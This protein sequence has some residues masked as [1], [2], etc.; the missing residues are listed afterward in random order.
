VPHRRRRGSKL[1][2]QNPAFN[3]HVNPFL[4]IWRAPRPSGITDMPATV[5]RFWCRKGYEA[6]TVFGHIFTRTQEQADRLNARFD[7]L[8]NH[9]MIHLKQA[10]STGNSWMLFYLRYFWY[11]ARLIGHIR[12]MKGALYYLNP[13]EMEAYRHMWERDYL[14][15][16]AD[17]ANEW[18][19]FARMSPAARHRYV[20]KYLNI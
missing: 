13:F 10:Q 12:R 2:I 19:T 17:G 1:R 14:E 16:C 4:L 7:A 3:R 5:S 15:R 20:N 6:A 8:K 11:S 18:R 9:E